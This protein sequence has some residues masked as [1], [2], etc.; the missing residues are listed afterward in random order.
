MDK[1]ERAFVHNL[2]QAL[3][4]KS[5]SVGSGTN[6]FP[7]LIKT[8][9]TLEYDERHFARATERNDRRFGGIAKPTRTKAIVSYRDGDVVGGSAP[10]IGAD[11]RGRAMLEKMGWSSG[12]ALGASRQGILQP[13]THTVKTTKLGLR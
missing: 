3:N 5:K 12:T 4:L 10:E 7:T 13:I 8:S 1:K 6:R 9:R 11:N 2:A